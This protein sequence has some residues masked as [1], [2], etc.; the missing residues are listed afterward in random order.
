MITQPTEFTN[1]WVDIYDTDRLNKDGKPYCIAVC[2]HK[3]FVEYRWEK[4]KK[5]NEESK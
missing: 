5:M 2:V 1:D 4:Y 3:D